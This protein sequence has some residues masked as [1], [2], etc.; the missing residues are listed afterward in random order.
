MSSDRIQ[1]VIA[2]DHP[3]IRAGVRALLEMAEDIEV[4]AEA[5]TSEEAIEAAADL[6]PDVVMMDLR[7]PRVGGV[8]ATRVIVRQ[9]PHIAVL[10]LTMVED[11]DSVFAALRAGARGY[12]LKEAGAAELLRAVHAVASGGFITSP[13]VAS[14][15]TQF[16]T[17]PVTE[18]HAEAFP[19]L[20]Q[21][22][23]EVLDLIAQG[24]NNAHIARQLV[25]SPKTVRNH[26]SN[27]FAKLHA[28]DRADAI[29]RA[30]EAGLGQRKTAP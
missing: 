5:S 18:H 15:V 23:H 19:T 21:R 3:S 30:R 1:V 27:I 13:A 14:W 4:I 10:V 9:S 8:E 16:F 25:L 6:Q 22:E 11:G 7:M 28:A 26:I 12:L 2:D 29:V 20:T 24:R 17:T